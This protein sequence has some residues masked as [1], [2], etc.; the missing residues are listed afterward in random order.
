MEN[1]L[2]LP[3]GQMRL[4][5]TGYESQFVPDG[6]DQTIVGLPASTMYTDEHYR[7]LEKFVNASQP[8]FFDQILADLTSKKYVQD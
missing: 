5:F 2:F 1:M 8:L 6:I 7:F 3:R 4:V